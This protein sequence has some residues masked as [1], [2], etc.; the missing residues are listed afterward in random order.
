MGNDLSSLVKANNSQTGN[1]SEEYSELDNDIYDDNDVQQDQIAADRMVGPP[2]PSV[3]QFEC[4]GEEIYSCAPGENT[5]HY[6]GHN[7]LI[8]LTNRINFIL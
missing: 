2:L 6:I 1:G 3:L 5:P 4:I 7:G 8:F